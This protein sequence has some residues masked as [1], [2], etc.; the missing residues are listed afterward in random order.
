MMI[1]MSNQDNELT[2]VKCITIFS[3]RNI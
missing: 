1:T 3:R 2:I